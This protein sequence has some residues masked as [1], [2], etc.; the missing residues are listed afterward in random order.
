MQMAVGLSE[1]EFD[2]LPLQVPV[3]HPRG[4]VSRCRCGTVGPPVGTGSRAMAEQ[5]RLESRVSGGPTVNSHKRSA[6]AGR[7]LRQRSGRRCPVPL[8]A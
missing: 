3:E 5:L 1:M 4:E 8:S 2:V 6:A 7:E